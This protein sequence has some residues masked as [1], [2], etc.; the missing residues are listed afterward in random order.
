MPLATAA[1]AAATESHT[2][3]A[4]REGA[5]PAADRPA[6]VASPSTSAGT[7]K[8]MSPTSTP[9]TGSR[10]GP[11]AIA[12]TNRAEISLC[13]DSDGFDSDRTIETHIDDWQVPLETNGLPAE[14]GDH[15]VRSPLSL[16]RLAARVAIAH[17]PGAGLRAVRLPARFRPSGGLR[18]RTHH[19]AAARAGRP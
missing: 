15:G 9:S 11:A 7:A 4:R 3:T 10:N 17:D 18:P 14:T 16:L 2:Q 6:S 12:S 1:T 5:L 19:P 8:P 13:A